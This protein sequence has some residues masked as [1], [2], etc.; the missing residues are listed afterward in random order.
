MISD[1]GSFRRNGEWFTAYCPEVFDTD[2]VS[3]HQRKDSLVT[4]RIENC[5]IEEFEQ[6]APA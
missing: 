4:A 5:P 2:H 6:G 1:A 3:L